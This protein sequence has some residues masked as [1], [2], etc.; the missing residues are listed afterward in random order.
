MAK[1]ATRIAVSVAVLAIGI[2]FGTRLT[3]DA[4]DNAAAPGSVDDPVVT[5]SYVDQKIASLQGG[6]NGQTPV[7]T[8]DTTS[9][10]IV[11][12]KNG[13]ILIGK[14]GAEFIVRTGKAAAYSSDASGIAD[15]T[16]GKDITNGTPVDKNHLL[17]FPRDG[18]GVTAASGF[19][20]TIT[21]MVRG[22]YVL[23]A[24]ESKS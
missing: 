5:K 13:Q 17:V 15:V 4:E 21:V 9:V 7:Q 3:S 24:Q 19:S 11:N 12:V 22:G 2:W 8:G 6:S 1:F 14:A 20:G 10:K 18:R 23:Q 16:S